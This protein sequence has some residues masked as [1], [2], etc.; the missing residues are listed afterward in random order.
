MLLWIE[1]KSRDWYRL[2]VVRVELRAKAVRAFI[3]HHFSPTSHVRSGAKGRTGLM[4][5]SK[6]EAQ[7]MSRL[8]KRRTANHGSNAVFHFD[9]YGMYGM[10]P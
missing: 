3:L 1:E 7:K 10:G 4:W 6:I 2:P 8:D 5:S 9:F